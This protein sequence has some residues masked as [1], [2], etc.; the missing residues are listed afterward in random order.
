M[1]KIKHLKYTN[2]KVGNSYLKLWQ[3][4]EH[5]KRKQWSITYAIKP[6]N[7]GLHV[8]FPTCKL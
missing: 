6:F 3:N 1:N 2:L 7:K 4:F 5:L 8:N